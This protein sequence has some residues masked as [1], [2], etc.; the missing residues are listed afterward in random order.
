MEIQQPENHKKN[1]N[2]DVKKMPPIIAVWN[3][4]GL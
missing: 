2:I 3:I 4:N 1:E